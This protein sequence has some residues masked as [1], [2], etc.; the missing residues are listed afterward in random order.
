MRVCTIRS[1]LSVEQVQWPGWGGT[2]GVKLAEKSSDLISDYKPAPSTF[3]PFITFTQLTLHIQILIVND[4]LYRMDNT[5]YGITR[6][7]IPFI[8]YP[9]EVVSLWRDPQSR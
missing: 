1:M 3:V 8:F 5:F 6:A 7:I 9:L 2:Y 4:F